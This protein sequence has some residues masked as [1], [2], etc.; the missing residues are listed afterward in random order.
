M[1]V[2]LNYFYA[3]ILS[4][5]LSAPVFSSNIEVESSFDFQLAVNYASSNNI[6]TLLLVTSGGVY[7]TVDTNYFLIEEPLAIVAKPGLAEM[8]IITHSAADSGA[9][10]IFRIADDLT[11]DGLI[12][13]GGHPQSYGMKYALRAGDGDEGFPAAKVGL[14]I[15]VKNCV[16]KNFAQ[17]KEPEAEGHAIYFLSGVKAGTVL[18]E[19]SFFEDIGDEAIRIT[20]TE[21][22]DTERALDTLI[23]RNCTFTNISSECI[24]VYADTDTSTTDAYILIENLTVDNSATRMMYIKNNQ[25]TTVRNI[26]V[27]NA[28]MPKSSRMDRA[29]YI[30]EVQGTG[31]SIAY[32]DT[33]NIVYGAP[34]AE[35]LGTGKGADDIN[36]LTI[37]AFDPQY[38]NAA[39]RNF[40]LMGN[41][42]AYYSGE[43]NIDL[44]DLRWASNSPTV[45]PLNAF[46]NGEGTVEFSPER[47]GL[48]FASGTNVTV[49]AVPDSGYKFTGWE[50]D[51][52]GTTNPA[53]ITVDAVKSITANFELATSVED[54]N[55]VPLE[56]SL[57]SKLS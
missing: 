37:F 49:T 34:R 26:L 29:D 24:R 3:F 45:L 27:T 35:K 14:N 51:L 52:S 25:Y 39:E 21:K 47:I 48:T 54:E 40:T 11:V 1:N 20:E 15:T 5:L 57:E 16:F 33:F 10:E 2:K 6:D 13:D 22:Y 55:S 18:V 8:P 32:V 23:I 31:S 28:R 36:P 50:G 38:E 56:Y 42:H 17:D 46:V 19:N 44:G 30:M 12:F 53:S 43:N 9:L 41:S 7:T 4:I